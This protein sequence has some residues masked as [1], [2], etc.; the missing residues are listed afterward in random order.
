MAMICQYACWTKSAHA[1][2]RKCALPLMV[3]MAAKKSQR[4]SPAVGCDVVHCSGSKALLDSLRAGRKMVASRR[5]AADR[6]HKMV[7]DGIIDGNGPEDYDVYSFLGAE[8]V[9]HNYNYQGVE[10]L[11][12]QKYI[13]KNILQLPSH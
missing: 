10:R 11:S 9:R 6:R 8:F 7:A 5:T 13:G 4:G 2:G 3:Y 1:F 12:N